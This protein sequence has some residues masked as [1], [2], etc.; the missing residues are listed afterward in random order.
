MERQN[1][2]IGFLRFLGLE[3]RKDAKMNGLA[4]L[5]ILAFSAKINQHIKIRVSR[6]IEA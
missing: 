1:N 5:K 4:F 3:K 6:K 2:V